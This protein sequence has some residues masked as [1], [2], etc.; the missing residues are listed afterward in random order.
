MTVVG[1]T[2]T[3]P[4]SLIVFVSDSAG[5]RGFYIENAESGM[6]QWTISTENTTTSPVKFAIVTTYENSVIV[7]YSQNLQYLV[8]GDTLSLIV[9][10]TDG[11]VALTGLTV[12]AIPIWNKDDTTSTIMFYDDGLHNDGLAGDGIYGALVTS[13]KNGVVTYNTTVSGS[14]SVGEIVRLFSFYAHA[15]NVQNCCLDY[16]IPGDEDKSGAVN[17]TDILDA[18]SYVYVNPLGEP[19]AADDCNALYDVNGDGGSAYVPNIN[20]TDILDMISHVYVEPLGEPVLCCP[21]GCVY[22]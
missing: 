10:V 4:D 19:Q 1:R 7:D 22:P 9:E 18:I 17:L 6:W 5:M 11:G 8:G 2:S 12:S 20:L 16:G 13:F 21:P 3:T 15:E 14:S